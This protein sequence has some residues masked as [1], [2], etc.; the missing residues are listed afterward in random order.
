MRARC[1]ALRAA[2]SRART[3]TLELDDV[4]DRAEL[5]HSKVLAI[6][7]TPDA[8]D[9]VAAASNDTPSLTGDL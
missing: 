8:M 5:L 7:S 9:A 1:C 2:H 4:L 3:D 6:W